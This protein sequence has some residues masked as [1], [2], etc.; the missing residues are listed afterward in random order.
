MEQIAVFLKEIIGAHQEAGE[1][2]PTEFQV[3]P[4]GRVDVEGY[5]PF[6]VDEESAREVIAY[7]KGRGNDLVIDYEHQTLE[8]VQAPAAGWIKD[9]IWKGKEGLWASVEWTKKA[10][11]YL[12]NREYRYFSPVA[13]IRETD[14]K[15]SRLVNVALTNNPATNH[16]RPIVAKLQQD[17]HEEIH[18]K[19]KERNM[20]E[21]LRKMLGLAAESGE[22]KV[23][24]AIA[25][26]VAKNEALTADAAGIVA[27]KEVLTALGAKEGAGKDEVVQIVASLKAPGNAAV[28]LSQQVAALTAKIA[29]MEQQDMIALAL[30]EGKTSPDELEKW[31]RDLA[32]KNPESFKQ[33]VLSRPAGSVIPVTEIVIAKD[34]PGAVP[35]DVQAAVNKQM[36]IDAETFKKYNK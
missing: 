19:R 16:L 11:E 10:R 14:R 30:K 8:N 13:I 7:Y 6:Y 24:E 29:T 5:D 21:K 33:I 20:L 4:S 25:Q 32:L 18:Q 22:D 31:G 12:T 34:Q 27:C 28:A 26:L 3:L 23:E 35:S 9:L 17:N 36:G 15:I 1:D 2:V